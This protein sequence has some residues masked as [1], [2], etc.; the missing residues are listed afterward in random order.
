MLWNKKNK[1]KKM[2]LF[3]SEKINNKLYNI[4]IINE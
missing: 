3:I 1:L 2:I 4:Y